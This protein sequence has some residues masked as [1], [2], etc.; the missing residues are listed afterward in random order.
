MF[1]EIKIILKLMHETERKMNREDCFFHKSP[2]KTIFLC[3]YTQ[4]KKKKKIKEK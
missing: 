1:S 2:M 4:Y 3:L